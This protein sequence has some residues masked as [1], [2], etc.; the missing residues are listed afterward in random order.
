MAPAAGPLPAPLAPWQLAQFAANRDSPSLRLVASGVGGT[1]LG[2]CKPWTYA[3]S[4]RRSSVGSWRH[5]GMEDPATPFH[6]TLLNRSSENRA[7]VRFAGFGS[8]LAEALPSPNRPSRA[9]RSTPAPVA[10]TRTTVEHGR[11]FRY[12]QADRA[13]PVWA[14]WDC[15]RTAR[16][17]EASRN[18]APRAGDRRDE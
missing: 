14:D 17:T 15:H 5:G 7:A 2:T 11:G 12:R 1:A 8:R 10:Q 18:R 9:G 4:A 6:S 13:L 3:T 16:N